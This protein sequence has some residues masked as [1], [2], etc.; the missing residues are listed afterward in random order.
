MKDWKV[1]ALLIGAYLLAKMCGGCERC[2]SDSNIPEQKPTTFT[3]QCYSC[4]K[5]F[6]THHENDKT[7]SPECHRAMERQKANFKKYGY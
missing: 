2:S 7:C 6:E 3:R 4:G 5:T 1:W